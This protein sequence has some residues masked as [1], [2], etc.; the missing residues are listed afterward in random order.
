MPITTLVLDIDAVT[1][2]SGARFD[3]DW[4]VEVPAP[5]DRSDIRRVA[6]G[7]VVYFLSPNASDS[8]KIFV[9]NITPAGIGPTNRDI[10]FQRAIRMVLAI[11]GNAVGIPS[12]YKLH[13]EGPLFSIYAHPYSMDPSRLH[14]QQRGHRV[15]LYAITP[16]TEKYDRVPFPEDQYTEALEHLEDALLTMWDKEED[17]TFGGFG[18]EFNETPRPGV[19]SIGIDHRGLVCSK[20]HKPAITFCECRFDQTNQTSRLSRYRQNPMYGD[21]VPQGAI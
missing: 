21:Q 6:V 7:D 3:D 10:A 11:L 9:C 16:H 15:F 20:A 14:F 19:W 1:L 17:G 18:I 5:N 4:F 13:R 12:S 8:S 2:M